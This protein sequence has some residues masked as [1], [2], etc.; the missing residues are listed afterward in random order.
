MC[1]AIIPPNFCYVCGFHLV[2]YIIVSEEEEHPEDT[3]Y[4]KTCFNA[5]IVQMLLQ[6]QYPE[7]CLCEEL[8]KQICACRILKD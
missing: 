2:D 5:R 6:Q 8:C 1:P 4:C 7:R 3:Y